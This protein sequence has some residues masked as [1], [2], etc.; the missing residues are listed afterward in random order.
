L[1]DASSESLRLLLLLLLLLC[2]AH[3]VNYPPH[4][5]GRTTQVTTQQRALE[6]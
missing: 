1:P 2:M 3:V 5:G 6:A 4:K